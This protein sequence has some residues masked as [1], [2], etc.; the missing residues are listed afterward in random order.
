M[1]KS[2]FNELKRLITTV[3]ESSL[4]KLDLK[5]KLFELTINKEEKK[6]TALPSTSYQFLS[7]PQAQI[8]STNDLSSTYSNIST[9]ASTSPRIGQSENIKEEKETYIE[10]QSPMAGT[11]Y[12]AASPG[13]APFVKVG[14]KVSTNQTICIIE[15]MKLMNEIEAET[16]GEI[17]EILV[18]NG[19]LVEY[20]K[21]L[22]KIKPL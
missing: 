1:K 3:N 9:K 7:L 16:N 18:K 8:A 19:E 10:I 17:V 12:E 5:N 13:E 15:A 2:L 6:C 14:R 21:T 20:G 11:F 22:M 4:I